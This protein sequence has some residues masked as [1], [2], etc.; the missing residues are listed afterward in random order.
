MLR[1]GIKTVNTACQ[2]R[3]CDNFCAQHLSSI[4][5]TLTSRHFTAIPFS[6]GGDHDTT[7]WV[8]ETAMICKSDTQVGGCALLNS[9]G[10]DR[11]FSVR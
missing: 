1:I 6:T 3:H 5:C 9:N 2:C 10:F 4:L 8:N 7:T 11:A